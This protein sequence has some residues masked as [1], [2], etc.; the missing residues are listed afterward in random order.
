[1]PEVCY[2]CAWRHG[3]LCDV[4]SELLPEGWQTEDGGCQARATS[5]QRSQVLEACREYAA[6][7]TRTAQ[8]SA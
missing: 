7:M 2:H 5:R 1:M 3:R 6:R 8:M 4:F